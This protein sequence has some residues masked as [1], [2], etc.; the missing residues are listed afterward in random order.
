L[1]ILY[2]GNDLAL[3][4]SLANALNGFQ[5]VR[6]PDENTSRLFLKHGLDYALILADETLPDGAGL[7]LALYARSLARYART[8]VVILSGDVRDVG[9]RVRF[10]RPHD[11]QSLSKTVRELTG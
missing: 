8:P 3:P 6:A 5:I 1:K 10:V 9:E 11:H 7:A 2:A 4:K